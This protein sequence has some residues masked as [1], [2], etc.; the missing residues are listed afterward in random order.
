MPLCADLILTPFRHMYESTPSPYG[1]P[2]HQRKELR[3]MEHTL[4]VA[5]SLGLPA[6]FLVEAEGA[7][8]KESLFP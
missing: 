5:D 8:P 1:K 6:P 4:I 7:P 2:K 3:R